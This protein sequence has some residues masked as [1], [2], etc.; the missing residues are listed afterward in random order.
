LLIS[1]KPPPNQNAPVCPCNRQNRRYRRSIRFR[2][3]Q[4]PGRTNHATLVASADK[5]S[6]RTRQLLCTNAGKSGGKKYVVG[7][8]AAEDGGRERVVCTNA[9]KVGGRVRVICTDAAEDGS[10]ERVVYTNAGKDGGR[11]RVVCTDAGKDGGRVSVVCTNAG[12]GDGR[13]RV[14]CTDAGK[15]GGRVYVVG[16]DA[17][18]SGGGECA[19]GTGAA[20]GKRATGLSGGRI[21]DSG[22]CIRVGATGMTASGC[23]GIKGI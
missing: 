13:V 16:T 14:V 9:G 12:K 4:T 2:G 8:D 23:N 21:D 18:K 20:E 3:K 5:R 19:V 17:G 15:D 22:D 7:A 11:V 1:D 10:R 6:E